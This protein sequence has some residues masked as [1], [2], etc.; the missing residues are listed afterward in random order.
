M[1]NTATQNLGEIKEITKT[2]LSEFIPPK[3]MAVLEDSTA[4]ITGGILDSITIVELAA[5]LEDHFDIKFQ[6]F[7]MSVDYFDT[8][9]D[10]AGVV[11]QK[12]NE[13]Q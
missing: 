8:L 3:K 7:E 13:S 10:I 1:S 9:S 2:Y 12:I 5:S 11:L 4:L 6:N